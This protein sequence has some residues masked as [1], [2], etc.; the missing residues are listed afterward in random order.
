MPGSSEGAELARSQ[1]TAGVDL[2]GTK[3]Q[4]VVVRDGE[5]VGSARTLTPQT[6][7]SGDVIEAIAQ[8]VLTSLERAQASTEDLAAIGVGT[9]GEVDAEAGAVVLAANVPGFSD[10]V[11]L[12]PLVSK[13][14][15]GART[16]L[17][18]DVSVGVLGEYTRGA[19]PPVHE[20]AGSV[21]RLGSRGR[22]DPR[23]AAPRRAGR[24][25]RARP[26]G[27]EAQRPLVLVR[28]SGMRR[29]VRRA[30]EDGAE[31]AKPREAR[32]QDGSSFGSWRSAAANA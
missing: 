9:P 14:L 24:R 1:V 7:I 20:R 2:G 4:S 28:P 18:N 15:G 13:A 31:G 5:V 23:W 19:A 27:R 11:E 26:H 12:G 16:T 17:G 10:R 6:G 29:G 8:T 32:A 25:R 30:G 3:I 22:V 21:G